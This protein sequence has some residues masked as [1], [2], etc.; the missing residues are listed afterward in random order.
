MSGKKEISDKKENFFTGARQF[1]HKFGILRHLS[2]MQGEKMNQSGQAALMDS[3]F[4][5]TI[6]ATICTSLF[7][8]TINY[9]LQMESQLNSFY[10]SDFAN[11]AL[12]VITYIN[13]ARD[14]SS[15]LSLAASGVKEYDYL[16]ALIKEDYANEAQTPKHLTQRTI[17]AIATTLNS[18]LKPF[19]GSLD[20]A[21]YLVNES[22]TKPLALIMAVHKKT[23]SVGSNSSSSALCEDLKN[24]EGFVCR[25]YYYCLPSAKETLAKKIYP[26]VGQVNTALAR[27]TLVDWASSG[28]S[29]PH[30]FQMGLDVWVSKDLNILSNLDAPAQ[31]ADFNCSLILMD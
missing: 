13:V 10:S 8:F 16:L 26:Y 3:I 11:D 20:Y 1:I 5:L 27:V 15:A 4:F 29:T 14:G 12:K 23:T 9:G 19:E 22:D 28:D 7:F 31:I 17:K 6:V 24:G 2:F 25:N 21:F 18:V 30:A